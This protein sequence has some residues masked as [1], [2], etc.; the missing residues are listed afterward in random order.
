[1]RLAQQPASLPSMTVWACCTSANF[2]LL[3]VVFGAGTGCGLMFVNNLGAHAV[4]L[5]HG[6]IETIETHAT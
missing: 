5:P 4:H 1:M 3:F 2:W 6:F